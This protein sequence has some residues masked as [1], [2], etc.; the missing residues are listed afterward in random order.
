VPEVA[1]MEPKV[2]SVGEPH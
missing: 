1:E 2:I